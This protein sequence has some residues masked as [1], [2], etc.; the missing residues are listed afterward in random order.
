MLSV[1]GVGVA[2]YL[3]LVWDSAMPEKRW[4]VSASNFAVGAC[5]GV[6]KG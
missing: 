5:A 1:Y 4:G 3:D 6:H 2:F